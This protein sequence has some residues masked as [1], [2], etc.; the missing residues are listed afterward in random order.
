M[1]RRTIAAA[2]S[3]ATILLSLFVLV[4]TAAPAEPVDNDEL[5]ASPDFS[6]RP[7]KDSH[8][9]VFLDLLAS[10]SSSI[11]QDGYYRIVVPAGK[12]ALRV[13]VFDGNGAG[14]W[15]QNRA[16]N[17][18]DGAPVPFDAVVEYTL[19]TDGPGGVPM[20][21]VVALADSETAA[22]RPGATIFSNA[23]DARWQLL[24]DGPHHPAAWLPGGEHRYLLVVRFRRPFPAG[25]DVAAVNGFKLAA[26]GDLGQ[27]AEG[28]GS[29]LLGGFVGGVVDSRNLRF[30][31]PGAPAGGAEYSV[32]RDPYP[33]V[34]E[35]SA[36][37]NTWLADDPAFVP[38]VRY[39]S[40][41]PYV[42][43]YTGDLEIRVRLVPPAGQAW[44]A[45]V[46]NLVLEEGDADDA[47]DRSG[48]CPLGLPSP[49]VPGIPPDDGRAYLDT[50]GHEHDNSGY[51]LPAAAAPSDTG[52]P[53]LELVDPNGVVRVTLLDL[54]GN[55]SE[56]DACGAAFERI[57]VPVDGIAGDWTIRVHGLDARNSWFVRTNAEIPPV[58]QSLAGRVYRDLDCDGDDEFDAEPGLAGIPVRVQRT[59]GPGAPIV[60]VTDA[61]GAW[62][63]EPVLPGTYA[64]SVI[65]DV[66][67]MTSAVVQ[68]LERTVLAGVGLRDVDLGY[69]EVPCACDD[70]G[71]VHAICFE[72]RVWT[73]GPPGGDPDV[74][75]R[76]DRGGGSDA[77]MVD[78][79]SFAYDGPF[80]GE[81]TGRN[82]VLKVTDVQVVNGWATVRVCVTAD[83]K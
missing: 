7:D 39:P 13:A 44:P 11:V 59:S 12:D 38:A 35:P 49:V 2:R 57:P 79:A 9:G 82:G 32:S 81:Q 61:D 74:Y 65:G 75:V 55:V 8:S 56:E 80:P 69:C 26:C 4:P 66:P 18:A 73:G 52:S 16:A 33:D 48:T 76:L 40:P 34:L 25:S 42:N 50:H 36:V 31:F 68:P 28:P 53:S 63:V 6:G 78:L 37:L 29:V 62:S 43:R 54:S 5:I 77:P 71:R 58:T 46:A 10:G 23:T 21:Q 45:Y 41:D 64:V 17:D 83:P 51:R 20:R 70:T 3:F 1:T 72:A 27:A 30:A 14:R 60:R 22:P 19:L 67:G 47:D 15:D 24:A